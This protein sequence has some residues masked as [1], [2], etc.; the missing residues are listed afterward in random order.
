M[1]FFAS[2]FCPG[3]ATIPYQASSTHFSQACV[4][5][6]QE[7]AFTDCSVFF[8]GD[9]HLHG[10]LLFLHLIHPSIHQLACLLGREAGCLLPCLITC[11]LVPVCLSIH[12]VL[13]QPISEEREMQ[14]RTEM[15]GG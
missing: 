4:H 9:L 1:C 11:L 8:V 5:F 7:R 13:V 12:A 10:R 3:F 2:C 15:K 6:G 14:K